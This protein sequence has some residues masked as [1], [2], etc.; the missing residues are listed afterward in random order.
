MVQFLAIPPSYRWLITLAFVAIVIVLSVTPGKSQS[1]DSIFVWLI[2]HTPTAV[3]K[4]MHLVC[5]AVIAALWVWTLETL[6]SRL[7][8]LCLALMLTISLG[9]ILEWYQTKVPGRFG[10]IVD[11][12]LNA[13]GA[14]LGLIAAFVLL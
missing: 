10:T 6:E 7:L 12:I 14:V 9:G 5:Y 1:D 2:A 8:R 4:L 3:Q 13:S 11:V